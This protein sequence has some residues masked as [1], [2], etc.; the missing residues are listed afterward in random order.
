M[1][2]YVLVDASF[3]LTANWSDSD[4][5]VVKGP[6]RYRCIEFFG[7]KSKVQGTVMVGAKPQELVLLA[8]HA[9]ATLRAEE[10]RAKEGQL[11]MKSHIV[12][13]CKGAKRKQAAAK[14]R[15]ARTTATET[16]KASRRFQIGAVVQAAAAA[17]PTSGTSAASASVEKAT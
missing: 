4:A 1:P 2:D 15:V 9:A 10:D 16:K 11:D 7:E 12:D 3:E 13:A 5:C 14:A 6:C 8:K 17:A